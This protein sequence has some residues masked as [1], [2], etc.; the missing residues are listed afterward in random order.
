MAVHR[1]PAR[2]SE[3]L[4]Y[5]GKALPAKRDGILPDEW[6]AWRFGY[7]SAAAQLV[8]SGAWSWALSSGR[9]GPDDGTAK[10]WGGIDG[11]SVQRSA[12]LCSVRDRGGGDHG[13]ER[14]LGK[15]Y[16]R[17][18]RG[19]SERSAAARPSGLSPSAGCCA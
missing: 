1:L 7:P 4:R 6:S 17:A 14:R 19:P 2:P 3:E 10:L 11:V 18:E 15:K 16:N 9:A 8:S 12:S 5:G 13:R